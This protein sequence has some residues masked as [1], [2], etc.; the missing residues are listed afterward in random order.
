MEVEKL[1]LLLREKLYKIAGSRL[2]G[3]TLARNEWREVCDAIEHPIQLNRQ[4]AIATAAKIIADD[5]TLPD[6]I[7]GALM[8]MTNAGGAKP[9][10]VTNE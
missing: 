8:Q 7:A 4:R 2:H 1:V 9:Y 6:E 3:N 5:P 10:E